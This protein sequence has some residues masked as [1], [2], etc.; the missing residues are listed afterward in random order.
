M[1]VEHEWL[2]A[3]RNHDV[4]TLDRILAA[5]WTDNDWQGRLV[6]REQYLDYFS[7]A[8]PATP[9]PAQRFEE[10][11]VRFLENR[12]VAIATGMIITDTAD[13]PA[14]KPHR[15]RFTDVFIW[16]DDRWQAVS[17]QE[18]HLPDAK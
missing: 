6:T 2:D 14:G 4:K 17:A 8:P 1:K 18:T 16:R 13:S 10:T 11:N 9:Q 15:S 3:L 5:E 12:N 7:H